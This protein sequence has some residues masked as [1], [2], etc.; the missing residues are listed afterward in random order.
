MGDV[1]F[2]KFNSERYLRKANTDFILKIIFSN[3]EAQKS[4]PGHK[5]FFML[6]R[7][8]ELKQVFCLLDKN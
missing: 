5:I 3:L 7:K 4:N 6:R 1:Y 2:W 8:Q